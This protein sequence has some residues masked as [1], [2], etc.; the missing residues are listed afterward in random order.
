MKHNLLKRG[1]TK[2]CINDAISRASNV[3]KEVSSIQRGEGGK[4]GRADPLKGFY[5]ITFEK[6]KILKPNFG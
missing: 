3:P 2:G 4:G 6:D 1:Y 5:S